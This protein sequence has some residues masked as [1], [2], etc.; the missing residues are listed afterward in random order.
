MQQIQATGGAF[1]AIRADGSAISWGDPSCGGDSLAVQDQL[2][3]VLH[4]Q[5]TSDGAFA[6]IKEDGSVVTWG[7]PYCGG[8]ITGVQDQIASL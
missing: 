1:A 7:Q 4:I 6:A 3:N 5:A 8:D 2:R